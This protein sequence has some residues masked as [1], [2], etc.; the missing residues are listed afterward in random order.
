[1]DSKIDDKKEFFMNEALKEA[2][3]AY[4]KEETPIGAVI[5]YKGEVVGRGFNM[6]ETLGDCIAHAEI[7]AIKD[8]AKNLDRWRLFDCDLYVTMEPCIM[9]CGAI[10]NSRIKNVY[11][12]TKHEKNHIISKHNDFKME[13][14]KDK[15]INIEVG[16]LEEECSEILNIFF[17]Q[18]RLEHKKKKFEKKL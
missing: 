8:A 7:M 9:C 14:Y 15:K 10:V 16:I 17:K 11:I 1:M 12:G 4:L 13:I 6:T 3:K 18:L 2:K 5:A